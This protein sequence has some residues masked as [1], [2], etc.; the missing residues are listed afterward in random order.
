VV[1][2]CVETR[3][4]LATPACLPPGTSDRPRRRNTQHQAGTQ[5]GRTPRRRTEKEEEEDSRRGEGPNVRGASGIWKLRNAHPK[6]PNPDAHPTPS[7]DLAPL[8][9][10]RSDQRRPAIRGR[11]DLAEAWA[12]PGWWEPGSHGVGAGAVL[13][14]R[15]VAQGPSRGREEAGRSVVACCLREMWSLCT[16]NR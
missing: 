1:R 15:A 13:R 3:T 4:K 7:P 14:R 16:R 6:S 8:P 9:G 2:S 5:T 11:G 10:A 12:G